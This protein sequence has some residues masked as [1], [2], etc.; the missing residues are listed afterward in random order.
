M[1]TKLLISSLLLV[2]LTGC[3]SNHTQR[4]ASSN[5]VEYLYPNG[6]VISHHQDQMPLLKLPLKVGI[7]FI[8]ET[9]HYASGV[10]TEFEKHALL[11]QVASRFRDD[12]S[13]KSIQ[14]VPELYLKQ[15]KGFVTIE[16]VAALH[17]VDVMALVSYDHVAS[18]ELRT[19]SL[20]YWTIVGAY[21]V[22]GES[23]EFQTFVDTAV[24]DVKT[25]KLLF[26][27]PGMHADSRNHSAVGFEKGNREMRVNSFKLASQQ[28]AQN[29]TLELEK[30]KQKVKQGQEVKVEYDKSY[31]RSGGGSFGVLSSLLLI[32]FVFKSKKQKAKAMLN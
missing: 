5:L 18:H 8:P 32:G 23:T 7:A 12:K 22:K 6:Q 26:R 17:N 25:R 2:L 20:A 21:F 10:L 4:G 24:F 19:S 3:M 14:I 29:L 30:F 15:G 27:A 9:S 13:V 16:Q 1:K 28:M 31:Y 11:E